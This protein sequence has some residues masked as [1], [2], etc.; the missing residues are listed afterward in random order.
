MR[1][2]TLALV[3]DGLTAGRRVS[4]E[5]HWRAADGRVWTGART[6]RADNDGHA[7]VGTDMLALLHPSSPGGF[8][9]M[10]P[11]LNRNRIAITVRDGSDTL[12]TGTLVRDVQPPTVHSRE[13]TVARDG[14]AGAYFQPANPHGP[15]VLLSAAP[16]EAAAPPDRRPPSSPRS[17]IPRS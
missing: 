2:L 14:I 17:A 3:F 11:E 8:Q 7:T 4:V 12:A 6:M 13:L 15:A 9:F 1:S 16:R 10:L 5:A